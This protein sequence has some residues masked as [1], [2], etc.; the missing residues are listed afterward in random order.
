MNHVRF[1]HFVVFLVG[2][3]LLS[4]SFFISTS[5][6]RTEI[7]SHA[8]SADVLPQCTSDGRVQF[9]LSFT[10]PESYPID[11]FADILLQDGTISKSYMNIQ[12]GQT[13][14]DLVQTSLKSLSNTGDVAFTWSPVGNTS[15]SKDT[16][17]S[18]GEIICTPSTDQP[19]AMQQS[20]TSGQMLVPT[21]RPSINPAERPASEVLDLQPA[22]KPETEK[23]KP[24]YQ[25]F[26]E[27]FGT[28]VN[29]LITNLFRFF[30][31]F[32]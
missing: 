9:A 1:S 5:N 19:L 32:Q 2:V 7:R 15:D 27:V 21:R 4:F 13:K 3:W 25:S 29:L 31:A 18:F 6:Q 12:P 14:T 28:R 16:T 20:T 22:A 17:A 30:S 10:N 26:L 23:P 11:L 24:F 8:Q